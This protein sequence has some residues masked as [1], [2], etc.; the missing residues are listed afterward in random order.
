M[1]VGGEKCTNSEE[2]D[3][4]E[5]C[6]LEEQSGIQEFNCIMLVFESATQFNLT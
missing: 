3:L 4:I 2:R 6:L 1:R 5:K